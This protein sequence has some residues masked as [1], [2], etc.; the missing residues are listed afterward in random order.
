MTLD[1]TEGHLSSA[2]L[3]SYLYDALPD[4]HVEPARRHLDR[5][6][7][8]KERLRD[9]E[10]R[11]LL[12]KGPAGDDFSPPDLPAPDV[13]RR[14][15]AT[16]RSVRVAL[17]KRPLAVALVIVGF[18]MGLALAA[19]YLPAD[20]YS[21]TAA[22]AERLSTGSI[23]PVTVRVRE[24]STGAP[25]SG[26]QV[27]V[28]LEGGGELTGVTDGDGLFG[29]LVMAPERN[30]LG[31]LRVVARSGLG[32]S[33]LEEPIA[34]RPERRLVLTTDRFQVQPGSSVDARVSI[35]AREAFARGEAVRLEL[36]GPDGVRRWLRRVE[37]GARGVAW[38]RIPLDP[39][40][41]P[42]PHLLI[43]ESGPER[44]VVPLQ[45]GSPAASSASPEIVVPGGVFVAGLENEVLVRTG[46][47]PG[48]VV[49]HAGDRVLHREAGPLGVVRFAVRPAGEEAD[50]RAVTPT[51]REVTL[52]VPVRDEPAAVALS[53]DRSVAVGGETVPVDLSA[54]EGSGAVV[55]DLRQGGRIL[56]RQV[57]S[58]DGT[59]AR[60]DLPVPRAA[61]GSAEVVAWR[62]D[63][64]APALSFSGRR[65]L[66]ESSER[67]RVTVAASPE[68][69][70]ARVHVEVR[71][72]DRLVPAAVGLAALSPS[73][74]PPGAA[75]ML[76]FLD[77]LPLGAPEAAAS[78]LQARPE[79]SLA[80]REPEGSLALAAVLAKGPALA[81]SHLAGN[82]SVLGEVRMDRVVRQG[83]AVV[84]ILY[85]LALMAMILT[86]LGRSPWAIL[87]VGVAFLAML[88][89]LAEPGEI[90]YRPTVMAASLLAPLVVW[91]SSLA[92]ADLVDESLALFGR[93]ALLFTLLLAL[94]ARG[95]EPGAGALHWG[96]ALLA[97]TGLSTAFATLMRHR[98][99]PG[100]LAAA[101]GLGASITAGI[102]AFVCVA[103]PGML[104]AELLMLFAQAAGAVAW[105]SRADAPWPSGLS[106]WEPLVV[107]L[108]GGALFMVVL[109]PNM[110]RSRAQGQLGA[111][112]ANLRSV[113][114]AL[115]QYHRDE[116]DFPAALN[117]LVP[118]Y[119]QEM[120]ACPAA[121]RDT[122]TA[123]YLPDAGLQRFALACRGLHHADVNAGRDQPRLVGGAETPVLPET[124][125]PPTAPRPEPPPAGWRPDVAAGLNGE[126]DLHLPLEAGATELEA[127]VTTLDG[128]I[129]RVRVPL[130]PVA[131]APVAPPASP[132]P[133]RA[134]SGGLLEGETRLDLPTDRERLRLRLWRDVPAQIE[135]ALESL[136]PRDAPAAA[137]RVEVAAL[138]LQGVQAHRGDP[139]R[140]ERLRSRLES[141]VQALLAHRS[142]DG[143]F[144]DASTTAAALRALSAAGRNAPLDPRVLPE[145]A[146]WLAARQGSDGSWDS[147][148]LT[149]E[150]GLALRSLDPRASERARE[151]LRLHPDAAPV[152]TTA[153]FAV[154]ADPQGAWTS[155]LVQRL[156]GG[157]SPNALEVLRLAGVDD[158]GL[159]PGLARLMR[160]RD[161]SGGWGSP[162]AT[163][164]AC[165]ALS[166]AEPRLEAAAGKVLVGPTGG[167]WA[168]VPDAPRSETI[169]ENPDA[170]LILRSEGSGKAAWQL[171]QEP[172]PTP[173]PERK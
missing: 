69:D 149:A 120:P 110:I 63:P 71:S 130:D 61:T 24:R 9:V 34:V 13:A 55:V 160:S 66:L 155:G 161:A 93:T 90:D 113:Q 3:A 8:C 163:L 30:G 115:D 131:V 46:G 125:S 123:G 101:A 116:G 2:D 22:V 145:A 172:A 26:V 133:L 159:R 58:L 114:A 73:S 128:E 52:R 57:A 36:V 92:L 170:V 111:C 109:S 27:T 87:P 75:G 14:A 152:V 79:L 76:A 10:K 5:C 126:L 16:P 104:G 169:L 49:L 64:D 157:E 74:A 140:V 35:A 53:L 122:Y 17:R 146:R 165:R 18:L 39:H 59:R 135:E 40:E 84:L 47:E 33:V 141:A 99:D 44:A 103:F 86:D 42:G 12:L 37:P 6:A 118:R 21:V 1:D 143:S 28:D 112:R 32:R 68:G 85:V 25:A 41:S 154:E 134:L 96:L 136:S 70:G 119:L 137:A 80:L 67:P 81:P 102:L 166:V 20:R 162:R 148:V 153:R 164:A 83:W 31:R 89:S 129:A 168:Q 158:E 105:A 60:V 94:M 38:V 100:P 117:R 62:L 29:G 127:V 151:W 82:P 167:R 91:A 138:A 150:A 43:A 139:S 97:A 11:L 54:R 124:T 48:P 23:T 132:T 78:L 51:G 50:L 171:L 144:G 106:V 147:G 45:V 142:P 7:F 121:G 65:I 77:R 72:G 173:R 19:R 56:A 95:M 156:R 98:D 108:F 15:A 88:P 107:V 4:E